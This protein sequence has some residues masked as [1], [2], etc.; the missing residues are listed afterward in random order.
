MEQSA[1]DSMPFPIT[2]RAQ[3]GGHRQDLLQADAAA[4]LPGILHSRRGLGGP[5]LHQYGPAGAQVRSLSGWCVCVCMCPLRDGPLCTGG[6]GPPR[7]EEG[8]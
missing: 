7:G 5:D 4:G 2:A 1:C 3:L 6:Q 8:V